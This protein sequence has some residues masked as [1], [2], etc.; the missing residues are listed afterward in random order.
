M[1]RAAISVDLDGLVHYARIH[2][3]DQAAL[4][5]RA[6]SLHLA[7][8]L[9]RFLALFRRLSVPA[10]LFAV[11]E[12]VGAPGSESLRSAAEA[13]HELASHSHTHPY[14]LARATEDEVDGELAR[15]ADALRSVSGRAPVGF[16]SPGYTLSRPMVRA[17]VRRGYRYDASVFPAAPYYL[18]KAVVL[19]AMALSGRRSAAVLD[20]PSV[21]LAPR[22]PY[23]PSL[24]APYRR[25]DAPLVELPMAVT[26]GLRLPFIGTLL[27]AA[28][29]TVVRGAYRALA[30]EEFLS[31]ELHAVDLLEEA[32]G[33]PPA[34][35]RVQ[36]DL[37]VPLA[38]K[39]QRLAEVLGWIARDFTCTTLVDAAAHFAAR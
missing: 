2:G 39:E 11:G 20:S 27:T 34:L 26:P 38:K 19:G 3:L 35:M 13:G 7:V 14:A 24:D 37:A 30:K 29:W 23:R 21:L 12:D 8:A 33:V 17:L 9:Q 22:L 4:D 32:D 25:G 5:A 36:R 16:R 6:R 10:T 1:K 28:P 31:V 15:A 18:A